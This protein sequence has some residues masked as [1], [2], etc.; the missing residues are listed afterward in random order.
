MFCNAMTGCSWLTLQLSDRF[1]C[2]PRYGAPPTEDFLFFV[3][4]NVSRAN[5]VNTNVPP[6]VKTSL[7]FQ[8]QVF[9][10]KI[11]TVKSLNVCLWLMWEYALC[12][13]QIVGIN[14]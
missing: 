8:K 13:R 2:V 14:N 3:F 11:Q 5:M 10:L 9:L 6:L 1:S 12:W 7:L 4:Q